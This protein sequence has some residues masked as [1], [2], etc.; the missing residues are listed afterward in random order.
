[1]WG[2]RLMDPRRP[3]HRSLEC[4]ASLLVVGVPSPLELYG[5]GAEGGKGFL[6]ALVVLWV[7]HLLLIRGLVKKAAAVICG[8]PVID[9]DVLEIELDTL[10]DHILER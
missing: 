4:F 3:R 2:G 1:M 7:R 6:V 5:G 9:M 8:G 10:I